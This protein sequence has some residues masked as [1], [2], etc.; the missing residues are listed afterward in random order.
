MAAIDDF[1]LELPNSGEEEGDLS[2]PFELELAASIVGR[3]IERNGGS[4]DVFWDEDS[5]D[6]PEVN[7]EDLD[8]DLGDPDVEMLP[9]QDEI[10]WNIY[11]CN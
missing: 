1:E 8:P 11:P 10:E 3:V 4:T 7:A 6:S 2:G 9:E 5:F